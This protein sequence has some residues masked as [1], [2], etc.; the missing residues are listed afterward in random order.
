MIDRDSVRSI[1]LDIVKVRSNGRLI[2]SISHIDH[3]RNIGS[4]ENLIDLSMLL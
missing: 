1:K 3:D 2:L 4:I